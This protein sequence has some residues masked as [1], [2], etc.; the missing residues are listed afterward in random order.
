[1]LDSTCHFGAKRYCV[2][3]LSKIHPSPK[4][5]VL[6]SKSFFFF[7][8]RL[9]FSAYIVPYL[10]MHHTWKWVCFGHF[11]FSAWSVIVLTTLKAR[12]SHQ[13]V[14]W[15]APGNRAPPQMAL[16]KYSGSFCL[17]PPVSVNNGA[18]GGVC[19]TMEN[20]WES[21]RIKQLIWTSSPR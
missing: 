11:D 8:W 5:N 7:H 20:K 9:R 3:F 4:Q 16:S 15:V 10:S 6:F 13:E 12:L 14:T 19:G 18:F 2:L 21:C 1:M 17:H